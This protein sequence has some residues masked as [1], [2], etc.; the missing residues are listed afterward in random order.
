[1]KFNEMNV[2][3]N[4]YFKDACVCN[5]VCVL[6]GVYMLKLLNVRFTNKVRSI[7]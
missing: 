1:M 3:Y 5:V 7:Q 2:T 4:L 6:S